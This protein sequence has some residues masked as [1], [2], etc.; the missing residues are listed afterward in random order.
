M[1]QMTEMI[2]DDRVWYHF[3]LLEETV[4]QATRDYTRNKFVYHYYKGHVT[5]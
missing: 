1:S 4:V 5:L 3:M 2:R